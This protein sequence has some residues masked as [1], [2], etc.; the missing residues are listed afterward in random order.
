MSF[1]IRNTAPANNKYYIRQVSG[2][3]NGA[4]QGKPTKSDANVLAN[5]VRLC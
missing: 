5:C 4:V 1:T 2:G 3:W